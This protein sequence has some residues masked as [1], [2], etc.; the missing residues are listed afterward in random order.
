VY[1]GCVQLLSVNGT[2]S[3]VPRALLTKSASASKTKEFKK[4]I[5]IIISS[6]SIQK[7]YLKIRSN[8]LP[9]K[10]PP[11]PKL[12]HPANLSDEIKSHPSNPATA[13]ESSQ[14]SDHPITLLR[15]LLSPVAVSRSNGSRHAELTGASPA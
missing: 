2:C 3:E 11:L 4:G 14:Q 15:R 6:T 5:I 8:S 1:G 7:N 10:I 9:R 13:S 12:P